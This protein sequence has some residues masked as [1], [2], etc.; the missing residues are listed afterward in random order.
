MP[1][2]KHC[3]A[4]IEFRYVDGRCVPIH[5]DGGWHCGS[6]S[7]ANTYRAPYH[8]APSPREWHEKEFTH[9]T[10]CPECG[11]DV[12][13]IRHNGGSVWVEELGWPWPKHACF[14]KPDHPTRTFSAWTIKSSRLTSPKL[15]VITRIR[16]DLRHAEPRLEIRLT[17]SSRVSLVLRWTPPDSSLLGALVIISREDSLLL[18]ADHAEIPFHSFSILQYPTPAN[19]AG[20]MVYCLRCGTFHEQGSFCHLPSVNPHPQTEHPQPNSAQSPQLERRIRTA[21]DSIIN[22][23]W[24]SVGQITPPSKR[25]KEAKQTALRLIQALPHAIKGQVE[26][27]LTANKWALL[28]SA[29]PPVP[30]NPP[31]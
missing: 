4:E 30:P 25:L 11:A 24:A 14:D 8:S 9:P 10:H 31:Q 19:P 1:T 27:R 22:Q 28:I 29:A 15:G 3:G 5:P 6:W 13:F 20:R 26:H 21:I 2:C 12:Y 23:A 16:T 7:A 18:H 17:D